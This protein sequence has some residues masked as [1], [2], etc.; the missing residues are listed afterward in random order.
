MPDLQ[1]RP[2]LRTPQAVMAVDH[3]QA[4]AHVAGRV[5]GGDAGTGREVAKGMSEIVNPAQG[6]IPAAQSP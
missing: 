4:G 6:S 5:E 3:G 1:A 2:S